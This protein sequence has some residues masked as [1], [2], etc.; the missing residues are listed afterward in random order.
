MTSK[1]INSPGHKKNIDSINSS[2]SKN[3]KLALPKHDKSDITKNSFSTEKGSTMKALNS[4]RASSS[5]AGGVYK[6]NTTTE[7][8]KETKQYVKDNATKLP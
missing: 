3:L 5:A 1:G 2:L 7:S 6:L 4:L 8:E